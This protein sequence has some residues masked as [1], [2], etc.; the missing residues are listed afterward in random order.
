M[1]SLDNIGG[2]DKIFRNGAPRDEA[3][4]VRMDKGGYEPPEAQGEAFRVHLEAAVLK[5]DGAKV[6]RLISARFF[7]EQNNMGFVDGPQVRGERVEVRERCH[8]IAFD[9]VPVGFEEG[10]AKTIRP[11]ARVVFHGEESIFDF[12]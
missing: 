3:R 9:K 5:G 10:G 11:R 1:T 12:F 4:L 8:Q 7:G 2:I 6:F